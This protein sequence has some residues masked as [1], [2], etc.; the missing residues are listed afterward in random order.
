V[1]HR[2]EKSLQ[3]RFVSVNNP[4]FSKDTATRLQSETGVGTFGQV[5][6]QTQTF[7]IVLLIQF[8]VSLGSMV[9]GGQ[10]VACLGFLS[11]FLLLD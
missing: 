1:A 8:W 10:A 2:L 4:L 6:A 9:D 7:G 3:R 11:I 5:E